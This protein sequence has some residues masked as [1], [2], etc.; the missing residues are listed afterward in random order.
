MSDLKEIFYEVHCMF[1][2]PIQ[3]LNSNKEVIYKVGHNEDAN[4][5]ISSTSIYKDIKSNILTS[6]NLTYFS[7]IHFIVM[8][9]LNKSDLDGYLL[10][11]P[12]RSKAICKELDLPLK[13]ISCSTYICYILNDMFSKRLSSIKPYN[14]HVKKSLEYI[15]T[16]YD[17]D[18]KIDEVCDHLNINKSYFCSLFKKETGYTF[19]SYLNKFRVDKSKHLL[20]DTD[21]SVLDIALT[22]GFNNHNYFTTIFKKFTGKNPLEY[23]KLS[24]KYITT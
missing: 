17:V 5:V 7:N 11:G 1:N 8:P 19:T 2:M 24:S 10:I 12:F 13:P 18:L 6:V 4:N 3:F 21:L 9:M 15:D 23:R 16:Y 20:S 22:V 14:L